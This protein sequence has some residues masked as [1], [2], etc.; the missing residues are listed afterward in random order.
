MQNLIKIREQIESAE[1][2][3][4]HDGIIGA[5]RLVSTLVIILFIVFMAF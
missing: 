4:T 5:P 3:P 2:A 1:K